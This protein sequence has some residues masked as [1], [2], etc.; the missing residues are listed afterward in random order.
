MAE[1]EL[2]FRDSREKLLEFSLSLPLEHLEQDAHM[3]M[4]RLPQSVGVQSFHSSRIHSEPTICTLLSGG[5]A[6]PSAGQP[7]GDQL[8]P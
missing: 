1:D 6:D 2:D 8:S 5:A 4:L 3:G 7:E